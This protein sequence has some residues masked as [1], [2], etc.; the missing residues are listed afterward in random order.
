MLEF[1][2]KKNV[3]D[4]SGFAHVAVVLFVM[5]H[6][7]CAHGNSQVCFNPCSAIK[8][9]RA[10]TQWRIR[11][12][13]MRIRCVRTPYQKSRTF[14]GHTKYLPFDL[15][16]GT[17]QTPPHNG[18]CSTRSPYTLPVKFQATPLPT[19]AHTHN[20]N[21]CNSPQLIAILPFLN[22]CLVTCNLCVGRWAKFVDSLELVS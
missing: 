14:F 12:Y 7:L 13:T 22:Y 19:Q 3:S 10:H 8:L 21:R 6:L 9:A 17:V 2:F 16:R 20:R 11:P 5:Y 1:D 15:A 18:S 4:A